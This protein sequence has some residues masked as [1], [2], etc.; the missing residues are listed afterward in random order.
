MYRSV[1]LLTVNVVNYGAAK[2]AQL[3]AVKVLD[4]YGSGTTSG[5]IAGID[6]VAKD[7]KTRNCP[8]GAVANLSLS[9]RK[10]MPTNQAVSRSIKV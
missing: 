6:F 1:Q 8:K 4:S 5:I 2:K 7:A 9:G 3:F 10:N